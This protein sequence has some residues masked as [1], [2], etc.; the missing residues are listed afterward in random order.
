MRRMPRVDRDRLQRHAAMATAV[1]L[2]WLLCGCAVAV[3]PSSSWSDAPDPLPPAAR[4]AGPGPASYAE[5]LRTWRT[6]EEIAAW[7]APRFAYD[8]GRA[9]LLSETERQK[10]GAPEII[11]PGDLFERTTGTCLDLAR[12]GFETLQ[13]IDPAARPTYLMVEFEPLQLQGHTLRRHWLVSF[14]RGGTVYVFSD[15]KRPWLVA[16]PYETIDAFILDYE[17]YRGR[18]IVRFYETDS[19]QRRLR[20]SRSVAP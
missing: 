11:A 7:L 5:A 10:G 6:P 4:A 18:K 1:L 16:G 14:R 13:R 8:T 12:F 20:Q 19:Y 2:A 3:P 15:S 17:R 9:L